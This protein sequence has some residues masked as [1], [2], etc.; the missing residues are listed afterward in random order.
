MKI[1]ISANYDEMSKRAAD[2]LLNLM[3]DSPSKLVCPAS[4]DTPS[5][6]FNEL[7]K[8]VKE[9]TADISGWKFISLDEWAGM[10]GETEGSCRNYLDRQLF[11]P[12]KID[13]KKMFFFNGKEENLKL[14]CDEAEAFINANQGIE[15]SIL[16]LGL[17]GHIGMNEPGTSLHSRAHV[18][19]IS[20]ET[21]AV[22]Q[23]Y[24]SST[25]PITHGITLGIG[26]IMASAHIFLLVSGSKKAA[27][28]KE[29]IEGPV[30]EEIPASYLRNHANFRIYLDAEAASA[31]SDDVPINVFKMRKE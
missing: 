6:L 21:Q 7:V 16:G 5:G 11:D 22:G 28:V 29:V 12:L 4:G 19:A 27:I 31:L 18:A 8:R 13:E 10:N 2:D 9:K 1:I 3:K 20:A 24:F 25:Q 30:S 26:T 15:V 23:K 17:N 14:Q